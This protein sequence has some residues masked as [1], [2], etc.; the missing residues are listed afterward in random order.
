MRSIQGRDTDIILT[1]TGN[2]LIVHFFTGIMEHFKE[3]ETFQVVQPTEDT[4]VIRVVPAQ[5]YSDPI[6]ERVRRTLQENG[7]DDLAIS[8]ETVEEIPLTSGGK[9][10]FVI[11]RVSR[12]TK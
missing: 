8:V 12:A 10:R 3:I 1:P 4:L 9:R 2:R 5:G 7:A 11:S 6:A